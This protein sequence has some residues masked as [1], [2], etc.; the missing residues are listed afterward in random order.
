ME[1]Q[2]L[3][4]KYSD[5]LPKPSPTNEECFMLSL[6]FNLVVIQVYSASVKI[7]RGAVGARVVNDCCFFYLQD[8]M[9]PTC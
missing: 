1:L 4:R 5:Q 2:K 3:L 8:P 9:P 6:E 7:S